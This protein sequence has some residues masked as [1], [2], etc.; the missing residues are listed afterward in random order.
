[1]KSRAHF[2]L[3]LML[4]HATLTWAAAAEPIKIAVFGFRSY[5][6]RAKREITDLVT[7]NLSKNSRVVVLE[8]D[9][10]DR[11]LVEQAIDLSREIDPHTAA[12]VGQLTGA[13]VIIT[14]LLGTVKADGTYVVRVRITSTANGR[15]FVEEEMGNN[16]NPA[17][18]FNFPAMA[19]TLSRKIIDALLTRSAEFLGAPAPT[20]DERIATIVASAKGDR[21]PTIEVRFTAPEG[22][23]V[24]AVV[25]TAETEMGIILQRAG[26]VV[27]DEKS[28]EKPAIEIMGE[29]A[30]D[31][32]A[33]LG[34]LF[35]CRAV[36]SIKV[37][38]RESGRI[39]AF[40]RQAGDGTDIGEQTA[41][42]AALEAAVDAIAA[43]L[44]PLL[45]R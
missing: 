41:V 3:I 2:I 40:D 6:P 15:V 22:S 26:F 42:G 37:R 13:D 45:S 25:S 11:I 28:A 39:L 44:L 14:G 4:S 23:S 17:H 34:S 29:A 20:R 32:G 1:M 30:V 10:L 33:K 18:S 35:P 5:Y 16:N 31:V 8:R 36:I 38:E 7:A 43:R 9:Q 12:R 24:A 27:V 21:R 19:P